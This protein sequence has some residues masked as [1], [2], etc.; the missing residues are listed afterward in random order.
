MP[1]FHNV[2]AS[3]VICES[4]SAL[5]DRL[6][7]LARLV[8]DDRWPAAILNRFRSVSD[9]LTVHFPLFSVDFDCVAA[10]CPPYA[11]QCAFTCF[12]LLIARDH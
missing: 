9:R 1:D 2:F 6:S 3:R 11:V 7:I 5:G 8:R 4:S 10:I 12:S